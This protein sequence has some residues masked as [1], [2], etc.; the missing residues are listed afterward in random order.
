MALG[1]VSFQGVASGF[2]F[3]AIIDAIIAAER[4]P[5]DRLNAKQTVIN[6]KKSVFNDLSSKITSL[7]TLLTSLASPGTLAG[8]TA[9]SSDASV[10]TATASST[11]DITTHQIEV[12]ALAKSSAVRSITLSGKA[13]P[14][15]TDG[16]ITIQSGSRALITV[17]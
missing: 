10:F 5:I 15:V 11:A 7:R 14:D 8:R 4:R 16:T 9:T 12:K 13:D 17:N 1:P 6:A 3:K 2:D